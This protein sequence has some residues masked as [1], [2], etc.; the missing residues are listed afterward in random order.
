M[1]GKQAPFMVSCNATLVTPFAL[2]MQATMSGPPLPA[3]GGENEQNMPKNVPVKRV[4]LI[5]LVLEQHAAEADSKWHYSKCCYSK[6]QF[7]PG[8]AARE[9]PHPGASHPR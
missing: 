4:S 5:L 9:H 1:G 3:V 2:E 6:R 7:Q 8:R